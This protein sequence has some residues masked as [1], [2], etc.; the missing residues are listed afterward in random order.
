MCAAG[1]SV[2][3]R[4]LEAGAGQDQHGARLPARRRR[5]RSSGSSWLPAEAE[6]VAAV[7]ALAPSALI[8]PSPASPATSSALRTLSRLLSRPMKALIRRVPSPAARV[9]RAEHEHRPAAVA[10]LVVHAATAPDPPRGRPIVTGGEH[11]RD[12]L[13]SILLRARRRARSGL[14][15][16]RRSARIASFCERILAAR[17]AACG[18]RA[19]WASRSLPTKACRSC[20]AS[21]PARSL[22]V[23]RIVD[24]R[25]EVDHRLGREH[26]EPGRDRRRI[27]PLVGRQQ[28][29]PRLERAQLRRGGVEQPVGRDHAGGGGEA[30]APGGQA[31]DR[32]PFDRRRPRRCWRR[33]RRPFRP[34]SRSIPPMRPRRRASSICAEALSGSPASDAHIA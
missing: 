9:R 29:R 32:V 26:A 10:R 2:E 31:I 3:M 8:R 13:R 18:S 34:A 20:Q 21:V 28:R 23:G 4:R 25:I 22:G 30:E 14:P 15:R 19:S 17:R 11:G 33:R 6:A 7:Q 1:T 27:Q 24:R 16:G 12:Q 5:R